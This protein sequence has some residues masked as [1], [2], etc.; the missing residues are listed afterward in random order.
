MYLFLCILFVSGLILCGVL[1]EVN[2]M[3]GYLGFVLL[4]FL[5]V[6]GITDENPL[7]IYLG[8]ATLLSFTI[9]K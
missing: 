7:G 6:I 5:V 3:I 9:L 8:L 1:W 2:G 4:A